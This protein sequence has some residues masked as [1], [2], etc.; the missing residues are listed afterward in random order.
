[1]GTPTAIS[2]FSGAGGLDLA[3]R[4]AGIR[5]V[6]Y[7]ERESYAQA[8]LMSNFRRGWLDEAPIWDDVCTFKGKP[9]RGV[10]V[11]FGG[12]PCQD[13]SYA[14]R[15]RGLRKGTRSGLWIQYARIIREVRPRVVIVENVPGLMRR[16][17]AR[18]LGDLAAAGYDARWEV[19]SAASVGAPH[20]RE[21]IFIV[22][23]A[24][25]A[26]SSGRL[27]SAS[28]DEGQAQSE[29]ASCGS[30]VA[31][32][33]DAQGLGRLKTE[34]RRALRQQPTPAGKELADSPSERRREAR[35]DQQRSQERTP[36]SGEELAQSYCPRCQRRG[37]SGPAR[38]AELESDNRIWPARPGEEQ[39]C[40]EPSRLTQPSV[41]RGSNG[42][43]DRLHGTGRPSG[44]V[45]DDSASGGKAVAAEAQ[46][47]WRVH[48]LKATG[49][50]VS[51]Q[52]ALK[53]FREAREALG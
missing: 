12:F 52:Q 21:R 50:G 25:H 32:V 44:E 3:A 4:W 33:A 8:V 17:L 51:P 34:R 49:N 45:V 29:P 13:V 7:V 48:R 35:G 5:T 11:V 38:S 26:E 31:D 36:S 37:C 2:L 43:A 28:R 16:G 46:V 6:C 22:A 39:F 1:M 40:W 30:D 47:R 27:V 20:K 10:D 18:V 41:G 14:G 9:W 42:L 19:V 23:H 24:R 53:I 15:G